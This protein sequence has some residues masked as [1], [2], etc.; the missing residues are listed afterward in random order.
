M[1]DSV[2]NEEDSGELVKYGTRPKGAA[3][4]VYG[5]FPLENLS[6]ADS[7]VDFVAEGVTVNGHFRAVSQKLTSPK[8]AILK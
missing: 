3:V 8:L 6:T 4:V 5:Q 7:T 1:E 2:W